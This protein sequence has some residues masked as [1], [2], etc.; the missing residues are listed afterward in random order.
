MSRVTKMYGSSPRIVADANGKKVIKKGPTEAEKKSA[1]V[2]D[3]T[4]GIAI[5]EKGPQSAKK[6]D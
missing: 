4:E 2:S 5:T 1:R 3:G 6:G